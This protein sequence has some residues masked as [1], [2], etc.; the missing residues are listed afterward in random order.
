M[1]AG[2]DADKA[3]E[4]RGGFLPPQPVTERGQ[5]TVL[6]ASP[7]GRFLVYGN[8][9]NVIVRSIAVRPLRA[10]PAALCPR[11]APRNTCHAP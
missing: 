11:A 2:G 6:A 8:G 1:A 5:P 9:T 10:R 3:Y 4:P 7:D